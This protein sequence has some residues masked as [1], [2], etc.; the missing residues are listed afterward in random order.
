MSVERRHKKR[1]HLNIS[2]YNFVNPLFPR[3]N[4]VVFYNTSVVWFYLK[5]GKVGALLVLTVGVVN[6]S[7]EG[8][9]IPYY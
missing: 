5:G 1:F 7:V 6:S 2:Q 4:R 9:L 8:F 3:V